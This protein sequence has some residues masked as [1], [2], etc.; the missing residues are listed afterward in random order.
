MSIAFSRSSEDGDGGH[1]FRG[2]WRWGWRDGET[3]VRTGEN[4]AGRRA[5]G[6][7]RSGFASPSGRVRS[8]TEAKSRIA[9]TW[10]KP[11]AHRTQQGFNRTNQGPMQYVHVGPI[12]KWRK[13]AWGN[14]ANPSDA[15]TVNR[16][17]TFN[18]LILLNTQRPRLGVAI[19]NG[20][21]T[22][23]RPLA[24]PASCGLWRHRAIIK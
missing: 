21:F 3:L 19:R 1:G 2:G 7:Q 13:R 5:L 9:R 16:A 11:P 6:F 8:K 15:S 23:S 22:R 4:E 20:V 24:L 18:I 14:P 17:L 10:Y 12:L